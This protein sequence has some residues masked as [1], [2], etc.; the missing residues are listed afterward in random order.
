[1][2]SRPLGA[3]NPSLLAQCEEP[4]RP[5]G[6]EQL[7]I[8][9]TTW[10]AGGP[11]VLMVHGGVQGG[12]GGGPVNFEGQRALAAQGWRLQLIDRPGFG[13]SPSR[14]PDDMEADAALI[15]ERLG[16]GSHLIGHSFGGAEALLAAA[17]RPDAVR[18]LI[19]IEP[20]LQPMLVADPSLVGAEA[21]AAAGG[22]ITTYLLD[23]RTPGEFAVNFLRS[24]GR[25]E[26]GGENVSMANISGSPARAMALGCALLQSRAV[27]PDEML[28]AAHAMRDAGIPVLVISGGYSPG[29]ETTAAAVAKA[30]S[31]RHT[32]VSCGSHFVQQ[33]NPG[34]FN[35]IVH[36]FMWQADQAR[37]PA[38]S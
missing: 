34:E 33:A 11:L 35:R 8:H 25:S 19:L 5:P 16:D 36:E 18:S 21:G 12:I 31:G 32:V 28:A 10:G 14:G 9:V 22:V 37:R 23:S 38:R 13:C 24:M 26:D 15:A 3:L 27:A 1:M 17:R 6:A 29:Q 20:A 4:P 7:P 30:T 2:P